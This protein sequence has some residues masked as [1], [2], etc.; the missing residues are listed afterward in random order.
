[1]TKAFVGEYD[2]NRKAESS[3]LSGKQHGRRRECECLKDSIDDADCFVD[4]LS[5]KV[6]LDGIDAFKA[7]GA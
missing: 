2:N 6:V 4:R 5:E 1:M 7:A 3:E